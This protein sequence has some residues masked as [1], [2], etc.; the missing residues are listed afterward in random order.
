MPLPELLRGLRVAFVAGTL[1]RGGAERQLY[2]MVSSLKECGAEPLVLTL[3]SGEYW[4]GKIRAIGVPVIHVGDDA[5]RV[6]RVLQIIVEL[7]KFTP[8]V[9]QSQHFYVNLYA[10]AAGRCCGIPTIGAIRSDGI[11]EV[12]GMG[13]SLGYLGL[14]TPHLLA[15]NS[16]RGLKHAVELGASPGR[17]T[18]LPNVVDTRRF[19]PFA[20]RKVGP[21]R[22]LNVGRLVRVKRVDRF[23]RLLAALHERLKG[24]VE[25]VVVGSGPER[26]EL[27]RLAR[28][29]GLATPVLTFHDVTG[30]VASLYR[31]ADALVLTSDWEGTPNVVLEAMASGLPVVATDVGGVPSILPHGTCG[32][33]APVDREDQLV[34]WARQLAEDA[35]LRARMGAAARH[36]VERHFSLEGMAE[37]LYALYGRLLGWNP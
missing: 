31:D 30:D 11:S 8:R 36:H 12:K 19:T 17:V 10:A 27:E 25:G 7:K 22:L 14:R 16:E 37:Q 5:S 2:Y 4:E 6:R 15:A 26:E 34:D 13:R 23:L 1:G 21:V 18:L 33:V 32:F 24:Q 29:L 3:T 28:T 9:V 35:S 20:R